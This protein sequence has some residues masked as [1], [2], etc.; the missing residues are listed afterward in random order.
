MKI[1]VLG[2]GIVGQTLATKLAS[3]GHDVG[4][5][6]RTATNEKAVE[7]ASAHGGQAGT[8]DQVCDGAEVIFNC[9]NGEATLEALA[10]ISKEKLDGKVL[11]D[12]ANELEF[13]DGVLKSLA[14]EDNSLA[15]K[16]QEAYPK[17]N[18]VKS[19]NTMNCNVMVEPSLVSGYHNV[20]MSGDSASAK[21]T[22]RG[23]LIEFGWKPEMILDLGGINSAAGTEML[24]GLWAAAWTSGNGGENGISNIAIV[25]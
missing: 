3:N 16:I 4:M 11:V 14:S 17:T 20:F 15:R 7:W 10:S 1:A 5:G 22:L 6:S 9:T 8:F 21:E 19:L 24:M 12:V 2:T 18:V 25:K 23:L 13:K